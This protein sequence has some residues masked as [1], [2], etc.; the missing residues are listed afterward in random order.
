METESVTFPS[1]GLFLLLMFSS[2]GTVPLD[3][4]YAE[5]A[6]YQG[7]TYQQYALTNGTYFSPIDEVPDRKPAAGVPRE[8]TQFLGRD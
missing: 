4:V 1:F 6:E 2:E 7:R 8:L 3:D 5:T